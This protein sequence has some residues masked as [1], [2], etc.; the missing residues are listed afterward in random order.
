MNTNTVVALAK[1]GNNCQAGLAVG[2][3]ITDKST[4]DYPNKIRHVEK[5]L[6]F[7]I[8]LFQGLLAKITT[9]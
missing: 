3:R 5:N 7:K 4:P 2:A 6:Y 1:A 8:V 9:R